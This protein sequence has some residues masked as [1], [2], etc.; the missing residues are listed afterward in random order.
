MRLSLETL[1]AKGACRGQV[2]RFEA[3]FGA[4]VDVTEALCLSVAVKFDWDWAAG[5][6]LRAPARA[7]YERV[8]AAALA[9]YRRTTARAQAEHQRALVLDAAVW[10]EYD[11]ARGSASAEYERTMAAAFARA[12]EEGAS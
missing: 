4:E 2:D 10:A 9:E 12:W 7:E 1:R 11:R 6:L 3:L 8:R 5:H